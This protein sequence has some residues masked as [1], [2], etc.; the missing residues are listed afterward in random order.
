MMRYFW[1]YDKAHLFHCE[2]VSL[3]LR[4]ERG[5]LWDQ[6]SP[7][8]VQVGVGMCVYTQQSVPAN[9]VGLC[10]PSCQHSLRDWG[11]GASNWTHKFQLLQGIH[12]VHRH[13]CVLTSEL[14]SCLVREG[15]RMRPLMVSIF[16]RVLGVSA[17]YV[18]G[19]GYM[20]ICG[21]I[22]VLQVCVPTGNTPS[23][24]L[25]VGPED[26]E[27]QQHHPSQTVKSGMINFPLKIWVMYMSWF[28]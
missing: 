19:H 13:I 5:C 6:S 27:L 14:L 12:L 17:I 25:L 28:C 4:V 16:V 18:A 20:Q 23:A 21:L 26:M 8:Q 10:I 11:P 15:S 3:G 9:G 2:S 24:S 22:C 7:Q 1:L